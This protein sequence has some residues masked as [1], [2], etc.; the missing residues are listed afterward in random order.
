[1]K[2][3]LEDLK[4][5]NNFSFWANRWK[6][7]NI[8]AEHGHVEILKYLSQNMH[9]RIVTDYLGNSTIHYAASNGHFEIVKFLS[10]F[11]F[12]PNLANDEGVTPS[13]IA[14]SRGYANI[15][16]HLILSAQKKKLKIL[17]QNSK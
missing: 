11:T 1:M 2:F 3:L 4:T 14:R 13:S 16:K 5:K 6:I 7:A 9:N 10:L 15:E 12:D 8:A 17:E